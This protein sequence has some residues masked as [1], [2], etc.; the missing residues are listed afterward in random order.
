[1]LSG[2]SH[3]D[4]SGEEPTALSGSICSGIFITF[5]VNVGMAV[6]PRR[7]RMSPGSAPGRQPPLHAG[8]AV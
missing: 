6:V 8:P 1:M 4:P 3:D 7:I 5:R 2:T